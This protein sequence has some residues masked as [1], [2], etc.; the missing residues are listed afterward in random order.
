MTAVE[1][2]ERLRTIASTANP[3]QS[4]DTDH[5]QSDGRHYLRALVPLDALCSA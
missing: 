1:L 2:F 4:G 3:E 5:L